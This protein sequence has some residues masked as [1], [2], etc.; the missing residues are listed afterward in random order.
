V[1]AL[2]TQ[3]IAEGEANIDHAA[4]ARE[5]IHIPK[6]DGWFFVFRFQGFTFFFFFAF[7]SFVL[8]LILNM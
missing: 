6:S 1:A 7:V 2:F 4:K 3:T 8:D 5:G